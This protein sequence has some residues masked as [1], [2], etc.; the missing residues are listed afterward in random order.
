M[1]FYNLKVITLDLHA[2]IDFKTSRTLRNKI[3]SRNVGYKVITIA[4]TSVKERNIV[5]TNPLEERD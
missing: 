1:R 3:L 5:N 4:Y 2:N